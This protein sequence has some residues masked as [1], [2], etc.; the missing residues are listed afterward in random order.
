[1]MDDEWW[2][3][4]GGPRMLMCHECRY[5]KDDVCRH[6][7]MDDGRNRYRHKSGRS[8]DKERAIR[9]HASGATTPNHNSAKASTTTDRTKGRKP[10]SSPSSTT[11]ANNATTNGMMGPNSS[12]PMK[13]TRTKE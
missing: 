7:R 12:N 4:L 2:H 5:L 6:F 9:H 13:D 8:E 3:N 1:M 11:M 10:S